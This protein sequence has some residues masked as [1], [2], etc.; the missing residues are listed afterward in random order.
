MP[1]RYIEIVNLRRRPAEILGKGVS[2]D[3]G[4]KSY[5]VLLLAPSLFSGSLK[6][7]VESERGESDLLL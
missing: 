7:I 2:I 3:L 6:W 1:E 4:R 5:P